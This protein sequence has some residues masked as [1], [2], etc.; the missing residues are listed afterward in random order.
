MRAREQGRI[1]PGVD[2]DDFRRLVCGV[3]YAAR[4]GDDDPGPRADSYLAITLAG[5]RTD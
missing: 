5:L 2:A 4:L 3:I 1:R